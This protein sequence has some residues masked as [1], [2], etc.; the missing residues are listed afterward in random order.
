M[1]KL[2]LL[3]LGFIIM[4]FISLA[5]SN[6]TFFTDN[7][8]YFWLYID[9]D[10]INERSQ[11]KVTVTGLTS[12]SVRV[13]VVFD[14]KAYSSIKKNLSVN[15]ID[16]KPCNSKYII[17]KNRK[18]KMVIRMNAFEV[19]KEQ[20]TADL[21]DIVEDDEIA[22]IEVTVDTDQPNTQSTN[23]Q[24]TT[25]TVTRTEKELENGESVTVRLNGKGMGLLVNTDADGMS[26]ATKTQTV[27]TTTTTKNGTSTDEVSVEV[28]NNNCS[29]PM[30]EADLNELLASIKKK[31]FADDRLAV[32]RLGLKHSCVTVDQVKA[33]LKYLSTEKHRLEF[34][35]YAYDYTVNQ[36]KYYQVCDEF[37]SQISTKELTEYLERK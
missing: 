37:T 18:G 25:T 9:G 7:G 21:N 16:C 23:T 32:A 8:E 5:Q 29:T 4:P 24:S 12:E 36:N 34:A 30:P 10:R 15:G 20:E 26:G 14:H 6:M 3:L 33:I 11:N 35:K 17:K 13:K 1:K 2:P 27:T 19:L 28:I 22:D 31:S